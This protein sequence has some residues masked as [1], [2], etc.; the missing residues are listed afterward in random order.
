MIKLKH[1][2]LRTCLQNGLDTCFPMQ[3]GT[4]PMVQWESLFSTKSQEIRFAHRVIG[5]VPNCIQE[6]MFQPRWKQVHA[7]LDKMFPPTW[8]QR[9]SC[10]S[11][12][13]S[14]RR[15]QWQRRDSSSRDPRGTVGADTRERGLPIGCRR[16]FVR[17]H[18]APIASSESM[19]RSMHK[20]VLRQAT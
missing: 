17:F 18:G 11:T 16:T 2:S 3:F 6:R 4:R 12:G 8:Y 10:T 5:C 1:Y 13:H 7:S 9:S 15:G 20:N 19:R 14:K